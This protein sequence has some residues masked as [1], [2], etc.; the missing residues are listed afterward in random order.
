MELTSGSTSSYLM[1]HKSTASTLSSNASARS[2]M[3]SNTSLKPL[4][5]NPC[6]PSVSNCPNPSSPTRKSTPQ[7]SALL[8]PTPVPLKLSLTRRYVTSHPWL[9]VRLILKLTP[10]LWSAKIYHLIW[11]V[12]WAK[13]NGRI[14]FYWR[15][16]IR[17]SIHWIRRRH[18]L[19]RVSSRMVVYFWVIRPKS[20]II[21][22][23]GLLGH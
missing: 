20:Q 1:I 9:W 8:K 5:S 7:E 11:F 17:R 22:W 13:K 23:W 19:F 15:R 10:W 18:S 3:M 4:T 12:V 6:K 14:W 21:H 16:W 2:S